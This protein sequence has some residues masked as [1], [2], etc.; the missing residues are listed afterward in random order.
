MQ[1]IKHDFTPY[2]NLRMIEHI[3]M[4]DIFHCTPKELGEIDEEEILIHWEIREALRQEEER[5]VQY[6]RSKSSY[7]ARKGNHLRSKSPR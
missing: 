1:G 5:Q 7:G 2:V 6:Q 4:R 3:L